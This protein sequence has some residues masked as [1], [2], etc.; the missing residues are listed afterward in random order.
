MP[1]RRM[2][3]GAT[4]FGLPLA[5]GFMFAAETGR[6]D[7]LTPRLP[8]EGDLPPVPG[9][10]WQGKPVEGI[11]R[12]AFFEGVSL[13]NVWAS[14]CPN[15]RAEHSELMH[16]AARPG[17][18]LFGL[19]A[20][21]TEANAAHYLKEAGNPYSRLSVDAGRVWQRALKHRGVPQTYIFRADGVFVDKIT[22]ELTPEIVAA[23]LDPAL[24]RAGAAV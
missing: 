4:L 20:D 22:G 8:D 12:A 13:V 17:I 10:V 19:V 16:L 7:V 5:G 24:Q 18:R 23:R 11:R 3:L 2:M 6:I 14:W 15:C 9:V 1:N 21:D